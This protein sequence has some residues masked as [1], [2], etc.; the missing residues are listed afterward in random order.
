[1]VMLRESPCPR[2]C[3]V[4]LSVFTIFAALW[5]LIILA[6][7][8]DDNAA[9]K[10][11]GLPQVT[12]TARREIER[13]RLDG[14]LIPRFI[15]S[16]G[17]LASKTNQLARWGTGLC[18]EII[19]LSP[20]FNAFVSRRIKEVAAS[21]GAAVEGSARCKPNVRIYF[22][23]QPQKQL[24]EVI[25]HAPEL[26]GAYYPG[27]AKRF[28]TFSR[29]IRAWYVTATRGASGEQT[30]D[31][32]WTP[33]PGGRPGSRLSTGVSSWIVHVLVIVDSKKVAG[34]TIGSISDYIAMLV[35]AQGS[36]LDTCDELPS[37]TDLLAS[38]CDQRQ[39]AETLTAG[40]IA[41]L[42]GLYSA[43][44][45]LIS[46]LERS[47]IHNRMMQELERR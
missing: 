47:H 23:T 30:V 32:I 40:D 29:T 19:G 16:H 17:A 1:M 42:K 11:P 35:L 9:A 22:E 14:V 4:A 15:R 7:P 39:R 45:E 12:V 5:P 28:E 36:S 26:L 44:L 24:D 34:Y 41:Y 38:S 20:G 18:P 31:S 43:N 46:S 33:T 8:S 27:E 2:P 6:S 13:R 25:N 10:P 37:I 3:T 21:V